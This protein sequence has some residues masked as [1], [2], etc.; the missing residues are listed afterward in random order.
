MDTKNIL[1]VR[2]KE[3]KINETGVVKNKKVGIV[4]TVTWHFPREN[5]QSVVVAM[6]ISEISNGKKKIFALKDYK[7]SVLFKEARTGESYF[8]F[9]V[10]TVREE[11]QFLKLV[12]ALAGVKIA[13]ITGPFIKAG[14]ST[15]FS[16]LGLAE[17][18]V[19][20]I[21][22]GGCELKGD[23]LNVTKSKKDIEKLKKKQIS[24]LKK[25]IPFWTPSQ[26]IYVRDESEVDDYDN[27]AYEYSVEPGTFNGYIVMDISSISNE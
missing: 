24:I 14:I 8:T 9:K 16:A 18:K 5:I 23:A 26:T 6:P 25:S 10:E 27:E 13:T 20:R 1:E 11:S 15:L 21:A 17:K 12:S 2:I 19:T 7:E 3:I 22:Q 4:L